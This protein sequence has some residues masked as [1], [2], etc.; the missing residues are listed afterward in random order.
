[1]AGCDSTKS[2][3]LHLDANGGMF[4]SGKEIIKLKSDNASDFV[5]P[6]EL[7]KD[8]YT[9]DGWFFDKNTFLEPF[10]INLLN[11]KNTKKPI[12][13]YAKWLEGSGETPL[14]NI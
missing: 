11:E 8:G 2:I 9:F 13:I 4:D 10:S 12:T 6:Q 1:M 5:L 14:K 3:E 7:S